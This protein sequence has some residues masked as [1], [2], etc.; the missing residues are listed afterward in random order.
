M[1][2]SFR[3][4]LTELIVKIRSGNKEIN[5]LVTLLSQVSR[6]HYNFGRTRR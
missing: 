4:G 6:S 1:E 3:R 5:E 2:I